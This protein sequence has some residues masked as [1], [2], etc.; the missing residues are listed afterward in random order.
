M[1]INDLDTEGS[2]QQGRGKTLHFIH[3]QINGEDAP[4]QPHLISVPQAAR[5]IFSTYDMADPRF[6]RTVHQALERH[7]KRQGFTSKKWFNKPGFYPEEM[8][9]AIESYAVA[10]RAK[11]KGDFTRG[12]ALIQTYCEDMADGAPY[13]YVAGLLGVPP[14]DRNTY[15]QADGWKLRKKITDELALP[16]LLYTSP[17][18]RDATL[19]RMPS[20]A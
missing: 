16:C 14:F 10:P 19:S 2:T 6:R 3:P 13:S 5:F 1:G 17:S 18:P 8:I 12:Q 11:F 7:L 4:G 20:S 9:A 15:H